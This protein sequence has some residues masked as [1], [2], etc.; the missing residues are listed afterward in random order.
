MLAARIAGDDQGIFDRL[1]I[2][3][4]DDSA[5][6]P[7]LVCALRGLAFGI[8]ARREHQHFI[9]AQWGRNTDRIVAR[10]AGNQGHKRAGFGEKTVATRCVRGRRNRRRARHDG[11]AHASQCI[12]GD[13]IYDGSSNG[14]SG[15][16]CIGLQRNREF[17]YR[18]W[19]DIDLCESA[20]VAGRRDDD[21]NVSGRNLQDLIAAIPATAHLDRRLL[22]ENAGTRNRCA[23]R[24][25]CDASTDDGQVGTR[26]TLVH[27]QI[28]EIEDAAIGQT[29]LELD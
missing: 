20:R 3:L 5:E 24:S 6:D 18:R 29:Q 26:I 28:T 1:A 12:A 11:H 23:I 9:V 15:R 4:I 21:A 17:D 27:A 16:V 8:H 19:A 14:G 13:A 22:D 2:G 25:P 10:Q 7:C